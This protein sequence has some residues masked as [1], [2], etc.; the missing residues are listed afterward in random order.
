MKYTFYFQKENKKGKITYHKPMSYPSESH[1]DMVYAK[2][3]A[4]ADLEKEFGKDHSY[5]LTGY[6]CK[7]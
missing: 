4:Y 1:W 7:M 3:Q 6:S 5:Q 2:R